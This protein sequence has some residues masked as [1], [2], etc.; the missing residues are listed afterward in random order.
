M[1]EVNDVIGCGYYPCTGQIFFTKNGKSL[2]V[3][4][5]GLFHIW[6]PTI[7]SDGICSLK[8]NFGQMEF[9]YRQAN[10]MSVAGI[11]PHNIIDQSIE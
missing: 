3:A 10:G 2:G 5:T 4:Y 6:F 1:G 9:K 7:G 8:A 11:L